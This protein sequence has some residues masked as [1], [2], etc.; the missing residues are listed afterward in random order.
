MTPSGVLHKL[1][2]SSDPSQVTVCSVSQTL[3]SLCLSHGDDP[4]HA[5]WERRGL[6]Q[7]IPFLR[8]CGQHSPRASSLEQAELE[9]SK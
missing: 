5:P 4:I 6:L 8:M 7:S 3:Q 1:N 2:D 9:F